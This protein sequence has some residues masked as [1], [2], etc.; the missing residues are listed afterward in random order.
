MSINI[1]VKQKNHKT[2]EYQPRL[3]RLNIDKDREYNMTYE[4]GFEISAV[5]SS[6]KRD[7]KNPNGI[8]SS[9]FGATLQ[10]TNA[11]GD[12]YR[13]KCGML[14]QSI[15]KNIK[16]K[17]CGERV[18]YVDDDFNI[19]GWIILKDY[20]IIHPNLFKAIES[21]IGK[22]K[23]EHILG[24][25]EYKDK[26]GH[27]VIKPNP[28]VLPK[29]EPYYGLGMI[30][31]VD[32]F[33]EIMDYY[34]KSTKKDKYDEIMKNR[35]AVF[36][37]SIPV[38]TTQLRPFEVTADKFTFEG[39]NKIYSM[40][41]K[42]AST[43][44]NTYFKRAYKKK[45]KN[46]LLYD[47]NMKYMELYAEIEEILNG[48]KGRLRAVFQGRCNFTSRSVITSNWK[49]RINEIILPY[50]AVVELCQQLIIN[51]LKKMYNISYNDAY[52]IWVKA[53]LAPDKR[54]VNII[55]TLIKDK[56]GIPVLLNRLSVLLFW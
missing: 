17:Y 8:Y 4:N 18:R 5:Q 44:N 43:L 52:N 35:D 55:K 6:L 20:Y 47:L 38:F 19:F 25:V 51:I 45:P 37:H 13:C 22:S 54:V 28:E 53:Q 34:Y 31:F 29:D 42:I 21:Y 11:F 14:R 26:D 36:T 48:K 1:N 23:L 12:K 9:R 2:W 33:D 32:K 27:K 49:L 39:T 15:H 40:M 30:D 10:D 7:L 46:F 56:G 3:I 24:Y 50:Q 41:T 16:C